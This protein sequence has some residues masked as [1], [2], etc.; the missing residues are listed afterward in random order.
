MTQRLAKEPPLRLTLEHLGRGFVVF[1][2]GSGDEE[3]LSQAARVI[4]ALIADDD[5]RVVNLDQLLLTDTNATRAF[6]A[7]LLDAPFAAPMALCCDRLTGRR[8][9]R[10]WGGDDVAIFASTADAA[11]HAYPTSAPE[12][13]LSGGYATTRRASTAS[14]VRDA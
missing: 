7:H 3:L 12:A 14:E 8:L 10:R 13:A 1:V 2:A 9:L 11:R 6:L 4:K 5:V